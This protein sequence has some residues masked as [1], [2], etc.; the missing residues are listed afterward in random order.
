MLL[1]LNK[2]CQK[3]LNLDKIQ[4][5]LTDIKMINV[6]S[7]IFIEKIALIKPIY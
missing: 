2:Y 3:Q 4:L 7:T 1:N 5:I 6:F